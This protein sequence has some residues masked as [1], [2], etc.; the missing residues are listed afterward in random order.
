MG[1]EFSRS[2]DPPIFSTLLAQR[3]GWDAQPWR[4]DGFPTRFKDSSLLLGPMHKCISTSFFSL[5]NEA[6][7]TVCCDVKMCSLMTGPDIGQTDFPEQILR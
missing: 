5:L 3:T 4:V 2:E 7:V 1:M 6:S